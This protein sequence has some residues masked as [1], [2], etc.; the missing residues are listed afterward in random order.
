MCTCQVDHVY[1]IH[2]IICN[3]IM[4]ILCFQNSRSRS[5]DAPLEEKGRVERT[6]AEQ[7][8]S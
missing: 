5:M 6:E 1:R 4:S 3:Y 8:E 7:V 2:M